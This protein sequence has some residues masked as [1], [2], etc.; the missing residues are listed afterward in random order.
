MARRGEA[1][2][3]IKLLSLTGGSDR[4]I[5]LKS[6]PSIV[7]LDW[8]ADGKGLYC[9]FTSPQGGTLVYVELN[10][11]THVLWRS[12]EVGANAFLGGVPSPDGRYLAIWVGVVS[13][14]VWMIEGF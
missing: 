12:S 6:W 5:V 2:T 3:H 1:E 7:G 14:N 10:G 11:T 13:K 8:S 9:G 4:E